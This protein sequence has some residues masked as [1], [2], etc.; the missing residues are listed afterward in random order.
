MFTAAVIVYLICLAGLGVRQMHRTHTSDDFL[1][2]GRSLPGPVLVFT[3]LAGW[4][5]S[6]S[7]FAGASLGYR[8]GFAALWQ[9]AGAW[10]AIVIICVLAPRVRALGQYTVGDIIERHYGVTARSIATAATVVAYTS[11]AAFQFRAGGRLLALVSGIDPDTG[12]LLTALFC[13]AF[14]AAAGMMSLAYIDVA[15]GVMMIVGV[16]LAAGYLAGADGGAILTRL[17]AD[18]VTVFGALNPVTDALALFLPT[19]VLLL[20]DASMYQKLFS[21]RDARAARWGAA[22]W[23]AGTIVVE[24]LIVA[25]AVFGSALVPGLD[26]SGSEAI[27]MRVAVSA[28]PAALGILL[29]IGAA[30]IIVS[31]ASAFLLTP[32]TSLV[33]DVYQRHVDPAAASDRLIWLTRYAIAGLAIAGLV[34]LQFFSTILEMAL[35]AYTIY[36]A[37]VTPPLIAAFVWPRVTPRAAVASMLTALTTT[38]LTQLVAPGFPAI[39]PALLLSVSVMVVLSLRSVVSETPPPSSPSSSS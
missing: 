38:V 18:Q 14:A 11:I 10:V 30:A 39:F 16:G 28:L 12:T 24:T 2:A 3:L 31:T 19:L 21:S 26:P 37:A 5:G 20:G 23:L 35:W 25:V 36:G 4:I 13:I 7:L 29:V 27:I 33:R 9:S 17:R 6:G 22:G 8:A 1:L 34:L 32:A 15:N